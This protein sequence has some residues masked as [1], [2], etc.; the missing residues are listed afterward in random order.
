MNERKRQ[1]GIRFNQLASG[2][3]DSAVFGFV[4]RLRVDRLFPATTTKTTTT[5]EPATTNNNEACSTSLPRT[6]PPRTTP[7][8]TPHHTTNRDRCTKPRSAD[9]KHTET[10]DQKQSGTVPNHFPVWGRFLSRRQTSSS[11]GW[12]GQFSFMEFD[13]TLW[14]FARCGYLWM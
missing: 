14:S 8:N 4:R 11:L 1:R 9:S 10:K 13:L 7:R 5:T 6:T 2:L 12:L 3:L